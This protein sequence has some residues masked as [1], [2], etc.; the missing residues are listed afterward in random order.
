MSDIPMKDLPETVVETV[1]NEDDHRGEEYD[2]PSE[3]DPTYRKSYS[4]SYARPD[5]LVDRTFLMPPKEDGTRVR[6][7]II[8]R[9]N[10]YKECWMT[11]TEPPRS[12]SS[13]A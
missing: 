9:V 3:T 10:E 11:P 1:D 4:G 12:P 2:G 5:N 8:K 7:K 6:A 13:N